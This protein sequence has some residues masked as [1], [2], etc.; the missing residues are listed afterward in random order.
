MKKVLNVFHSFSVQLLAFIYSSF[1]P[2][3]IAVAYIG[4]Y[5][6]KDFIP[7][8]LS[9]FFRFSTFVNLHTSNGHI[10]GSTEDI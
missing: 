1:L 9:L 8:T 6:A 5:V 10:S 4:T 2:T 3:I 7:T